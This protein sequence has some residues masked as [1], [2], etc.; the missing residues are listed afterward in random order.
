L[1]VLFALAAMKNSGR[2]PAHLSAFPRAIGL[3]AGYLLASVGA[4]VLEGLH[5]DAG[6]KYV[7]VGYSML[8]AFGSV[9]LMT[10]AAVW[11]TRT[12]RGRVTPKI[13]WRSA[14]PKAATRL[15]AARAR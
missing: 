14:G 11:L 3:F 15:C 2:D 8:F 5:L 1:V 4:Q 12:R 10:S 7:R 6:A 13:R 9:R